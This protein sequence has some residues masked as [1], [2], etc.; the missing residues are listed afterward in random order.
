MKKIIL[1]FLAVALS[2]TGARADLIP[3]FEGTAP[4]DVGTLWNYSVSVTVE[5]NANTGDYFTIYDFGNIIPASN[6]QPAGWTLTTSFLGVTPAQIIPP[7][8]P[9]VLNLTWTYSGPT[10]FGTSPAGQD[11]GPFQVEVAGQQTQTKNSFFAAQG[12]LA[13]GPEAGS[14]VG[15]VG[16]IVV[17]VPEPSAIALMVGAAA[18]GLLGRAFSRRRS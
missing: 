2:F 11:I 3:S 8:D 14:K 18:L 13:E 16:L 1:G 7:D 4:G 10:I 9:S 5:Q 17:P 15:N 12:T 6:T